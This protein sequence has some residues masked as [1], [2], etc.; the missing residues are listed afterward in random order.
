MSNDDTD[1]VTPP[2][3]IGK[4][5]SLCL[6][7]NSGTNLPAGSESKKKIGR[8]KVPNLQP[9]D[10]SSSSAIWDTAKKYRNDHG[11]YF[12]QLYDHFNG[13]S[14]SRLQH[15]LIWE[16]IHGR[17]VPRNCC[18]HHRDLDPGNYNAENLMCIPI[19]LHLE[20]HMRLRKAKKITS[21]LAFEVERH[22]ITQEYE[23]KAA[24]IMSLWELMQDI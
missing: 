5:D 10:M 22:R 15:V 23:K 11:Y 24:E 20:L 7:E 14:R 18:I 13:K 9:L 17:Q 19:V 1:Q 6:S 8:P 16:R 12:C 3:T 2:S 21:N 4:D